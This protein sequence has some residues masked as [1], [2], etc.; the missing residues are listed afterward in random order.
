M[1]ASA[2]LAALPKAI[3][4]QYWG[5]EQFRPLQEDIIQSVMDG[6]H[7]L[8]LLPTGGGKSICY[9]VP[10]LCLPGQTL[11]I[12]PLVALMQDQVQNLKSKHIR[13]EAL[14]SGLTQGEIDIQIDNWVH[15]A[16]KILFVAPERIDTPIFFER[17][18]RANLSLIAV[19]EAHCISQWG[20]DFRPSYFKIAKIK[21]L[22]PKTPVLAL[23]ATATDQVI[24]DIL[25]KL[26][27]KKSQ[28]FKKSFLR[29][30]LQIV[31]IPTN[32]KEKELIR[33]MSKLKG[34]GI[35]YVRSRKATE[36]IAS[37][38]NQNGLSATY[39]H[40]GLEHVDRE[41]RQSDWLH[42]R[43][44]VM[45][46]TNA[47]G[48]GIDKPDV[49]WVVHMDIP[50]SI[51]EYYQ[52][53][54]RAGRD[55]S[56]AFVVSIINDTDKAKIT[57]NHEKSFLPI[58][59]IKSIYQSIHK[60]LKVPVG[61]GK[62]ETFPFDMSAFVTA[63]GIKAK[64]LHMVIDL[65]QKEGFIEMAEDVRM[66]S[67]AK[68]LV[69]GRAIDEM[70][71]HQ[72]E[73]LELVHQMLRLF[74]GLLYDYGA[75]DEKLLSDRMAI[76]LVE[77]KRWLTKLHREAVIDYKAGTEGNFIT[78]MEDRLGSQQFTIDEK[79]YNMRRDRAS[80]RLT[81]IVAMLFG[82]Q[83]RQQ[84]ILKYFGEDTQPCGHCDVCLGS[85]QESYTKEEFEAVK[86]HLLTKIKGPIHVDDYIVLWPFNRRKRVLAALDDLVKDG[87]WIM[88]ED[89][90][91]KT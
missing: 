88:E 64:S 1:A 91:S 71:F 25:D 38:L 33:L 73:K 54:G 52:E 39:Y 81:E 50:P 49:K 28:L 18:K 36:K 57:Y 90:I 59:E 7:T 89:I 27:I 10:A 24:E 16:T 42:N 53:I 23:T 74:E 51:E 55:G 8:A 45:V 35:I 15:G 76:P 37:L 48:M 22:H 86:Q 41:K 58:E 83:C 78:L 34:S 67:T 32:R 43:S 85:Q 40:A 31:V 5:Y 77:V 17:L 47:F 79:T 80:H 6:K 63:T 20:F 75:I 61:S 30:N 14:Y 82:Q 70:L 12:S 9:Q 29:E 72:R 13:A 56:S 11:V 66:T 68:V 84:Y 2:N 65:L 3:L 69:S 46:S 19:D 62:G 87:E 4:K 21:E 60:Y 44:M 26:E